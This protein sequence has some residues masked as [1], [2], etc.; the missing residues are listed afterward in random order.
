MLPPPL[1]GYTGHGTFHDFQ[2]CLLDALAGDISCDGSILALSSNFIH[3]INVNN[4]ALCQ[5][6]VE[7]RRLQ[8]TQKNI[9]H[10]VAHIAGLRQGGGVGNGEGYIQDLRQ[11]LG[12]EGLAGTGGADQQDVA[13]L[14]LYIGVAPKVDPLIVVIHRHGQRNLGGLL[15][16]NVAIHE[17]LDL[18]GRGQCL[19]DTQVAGGLGRKLILQKGAA[20]PHTVAA[21]KYAGSGDHALHLG[22]PLSAEGTADSLFFTFCHLVRTSES[23]GSDDLVDEAIFHGL[24]GRHEII[25]FAVRGD[26][27]HRF[28]CVLGEDVVHPFLHALQTL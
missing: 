17:G 24:L 5:V 25:P 7:I 6:N 3:L 2:Q 19:G 13:L 1:G 10:I 22:F 26:G 18:H 28:A 9:F 8:K 11:G 21:D 20:Y 23:A 16:H 14:Q 27:L 15:A 12:K 4:A